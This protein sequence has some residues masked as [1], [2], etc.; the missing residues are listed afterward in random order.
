MKYLFVFLL[1]FS[2]LNLFAQK[3]VPELWGV[4]VHDEAGVLKSSTVEQLEQQLKSF[5]DSTS[6]QIAILIINSLDG[7]VLEDYSLRVAET[8]QLGQHGKD[9]GVLLLISI[10]DRE[11]RIEVGRGLE[12]VL[13]DATCYLIIRNEITPRF[14]QGNFDEGVS[15]AINAITKSIEGEYTA[16]IA[17]TDGP[18]EFG[19]SGGEAIFIGIFV[20]F[21]LGVFTFTALTLPGFEGW[22]LY[23]FLIPFYGS[24]PIFIFGVQGG[25]ITLGSFIIG[26]PII[27]LIFP[28]SWFAK[29]FPGSNKSGGRQWSSSSGWSSGGSSGSSS[30][31]SWS[32]SSGSSFSGGGGSFSGGGSSGSW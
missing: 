10:D 26:F 23:L 12:G 29:K 27:K 1:S 18:N 5:E 2:T 16:D 8:W 15:E 31:S 32:S 11:M 4:R 20:F 13:T 25:L 21:I 7:D 17:D 28:S 24:F 14:R 3:P 9:N 6:N 19:L 22:F 30:G